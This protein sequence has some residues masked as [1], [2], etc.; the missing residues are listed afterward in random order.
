M[1][2]L[3]ATTPLLG[4]RWY[5]G[6]RCTAPTSPRSSLDRKKWEQGLDNYGLRALRVVPFPGERYYRG[7]MW[8][9]LVDLCWKFLTRKTVISDFLTRAFFK[10]F[11]AECNL[12]SCMD[13]APKCTSQRSKPLKWRL[14]VWPRGVH[15]GGSSQSY[16]YQRETGNAIARF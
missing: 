13:I 1:A 11:L 2:F 6:T 3:I 5:V 7:A 10:S 9:A 14:V 8:C 15:K 16:Q 12:V 4:V